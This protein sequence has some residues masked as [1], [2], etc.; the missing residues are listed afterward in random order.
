MGLRVVSSG[1][2]M[3]RRGMQNDGHTVMQ[4]GNGLVRVG[5][6]DGA[7]RNLLPCWRARE[8]APAYW[9][10]RHNVEIGAEA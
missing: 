7:G 3:A 4:R 5:G 2:L 6:D 9:R 1:E 10:K 8:T